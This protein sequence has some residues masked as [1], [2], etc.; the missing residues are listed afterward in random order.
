MKEIYITRDLEKKINKYLKR[1]EI[2]VLVG[3]RQCG[4]T[5]LIF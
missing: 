2:I 5:T 1:K 4:K 3:P